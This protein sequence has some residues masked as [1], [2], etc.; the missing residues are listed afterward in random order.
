MLKSNSF[1]LVILLKHIFQKT[2]GIL[3]TQLIMVFHF[4]GF[5]LRCV[6]C[7][8]LKCFKYLLKHKF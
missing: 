2:H 5:R 6:A 3:Y 8:M 4:R 7:S 1:H